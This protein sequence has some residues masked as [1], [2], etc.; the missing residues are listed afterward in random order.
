MTEKNKLSSCRSGKKELGE[1]EE[2]MLLHIKQTV[3]V[4]RD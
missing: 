2:L 1:E 4:D 3:D